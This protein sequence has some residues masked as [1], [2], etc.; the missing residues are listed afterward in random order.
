MESHK[1]PNAVFRG[2]LEGNYDL[3]KD[4]TYQVKAKGQLAIRGIKK[5]RTVPATITVKNGAASLNAQFTVK[6]ADHGIKIPKVV[7]GKIAEEIKVTVT[8]DLQKK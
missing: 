8:S 7:A 6:P 4:G 1:H 5:D 2:V 3:T